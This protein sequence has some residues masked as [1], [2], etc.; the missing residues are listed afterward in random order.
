MVDAL[1][2]VLCVVL[3]SWGIVCP[4]AYAIGRRHE[5]KWWTRRWPR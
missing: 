2:G 1:I 3:V 5:E 4:I